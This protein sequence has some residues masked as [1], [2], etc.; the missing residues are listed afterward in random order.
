[1]ELLRKHACDLEAGHIRKHSDNPQWT[2]V[3][4]SLSDT[5][6]TSK[7]KPSLGQIPGVVQIFDWESKTVA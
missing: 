7:P 6:R 3:T 1:M 4:V 5:L 2:R